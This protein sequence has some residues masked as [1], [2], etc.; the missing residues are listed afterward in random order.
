MMMKQ[1]YSKAK[2]LSVLASSFLICSTAFSSSVLDSEFEIKI[3]RQFQQ[4]LVEEKWKKLQS[5]DFQANWQFPSQTYVSQDIPIVFEGMSLQ[6]KTRL[7]QPSVG[8]GDKTEVELQSKNL[9]AQL[10][11][12]K[13]SV[14]HIIERDVG[15]IIG[16]FRIQ[17][18]CENVM[19]NLK[20]NS[21][22]FS[23]RLAPRVV[24]GRVGAEVR[25]FSL[26]WNPGALEVVGDIRCEGVEGFDQLLRDQVK[27]IAQDSKSFVDPQRDIIKGY[28]ENYFSGIGLDLSTPREL[29]LSRPDIKISLSFNETKE[30]ADN[31]LWAKGKVTV[32]FEK[33]THQESKSLVLE[34]TL[35]G[36]K[37]GDQV[38]IRLPKDFVKEILGEAFAANSWSHRIGSDK[39]PGFSAIMNSRLV[40]FFIWPELRDF[41]KS[42]KFLF[43]LNSNKDMEVT[44][45]G[46]Q[47]SVSSNLLAKMWAPRGGEYRTFMNFTVPLKSKVQLSVVKGKLSA[48]LP[49]PSIG[50]SYRWDSDYVKKYRPSQKFSA[51]TI[52]DKV[53]DSLWGK[54]LIY[55]LPKIPL[56]QELQLKIQKVDVNAKAELN[57][58][59]TP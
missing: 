47:Y 50:L 11:I 14:D 57:L 51:S 9:E 27:V 42:T 10:S 43:D 13:I 7:A 25:D 6:M 45:Q 58:Y 1:S 30:D 48:K 19:L 44:G 53:V 40:Q 54:I 55:D 32:A 16:R 37:S 59:L 33:S 34:S 28:L 3:P 15:G 18:K 21:G 24:L 22:T 8:G 20:K 5:Q 29:V 17:A 41:S 36:E 26:A 31:G 56:H 46:L 2:A 23:L 52:R 38:A 35:W 49:N 4:K 12:S 39:V